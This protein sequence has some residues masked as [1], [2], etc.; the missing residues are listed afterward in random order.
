MHVSSIA[1]RYGKALARAAISAKPPL[2]KT[3]G[4]ELEGLLSFFQD[5]PLAR[6]V[7]E[8]PASTAEQQRRLLEQITSALASRHALSTQ[9]KNTLELLVENGRFALFAEVVEAYR[10]EVDRYHGVVVVEVT[11]AHELGAAEKESL[12]GT[13]RRTL[14]AGGDVRLEMHTDPKLLAGF[15]ARVGSTVHDGSL[16]HQLDQIKLQL[17]SE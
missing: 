10:R 17:V 16:S 12:Q 15:V 7:L 9:T 4:A 2:E 3:V 13:L 14:A 8:S 6:V 11:T 1:R 5:V